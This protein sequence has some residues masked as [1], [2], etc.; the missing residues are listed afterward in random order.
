V[1]AAQAA[2]GQGSSLSDSVAGH[3]ASHSFSDQE[4][5]DENFNHDCTST[6]GSIL[7]TRNEEHDSDCGGA[8]ELLTESA[9]R[10]SSQRTESVQSEYG[11]SQGSTANLAPKQMKASSKA[12]QFYTTIVVKCCCYVKEYHGFI[13]THRRNSIIFRK[14]EC[15]LRDRMLYPLPADVKLKDLMAFSFF[16]G[17]NEDSDFKKYCDSGHDNATLTVDMTSTADRLFNNKFADVRKNICNGIIQRF[18][19]IVK[20]ITGDGKRSG[21]GSRRSFCFLHL[22]KHFSDTTKVPKKLWKMQTERCMR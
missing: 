10:N 11:P 12:S 6:L 8:P 16:N 19:A 5:S 22:L 20:T 13:P 1:P 2:G 3:H 15:D 4:G 17:C 14:I 21:Q 18:Q 9:A 7:Q